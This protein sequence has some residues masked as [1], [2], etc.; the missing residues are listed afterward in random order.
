MT[1][2]VYLLRHP[3]QGTETSER[4]IMAMA[5]SEIEKLRSA[6]MKNMQDLSEDIRDIEVK[7][8]L[9]EARGHTNV[10]R[11]GIARGLEAAADFAEG[12]VKRL[13]NER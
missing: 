9:S 13:S 3:M 1:D 12:Q 2:L 5:A 7:Y 8:S 11:A 4:N 6:N 10:Y